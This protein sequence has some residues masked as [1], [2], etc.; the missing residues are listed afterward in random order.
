MRIPALF[1]FA[2]LALA[3]CGDGTGSGDLDRGEFQGDMRG[4]Y[5]ADLSGQ[6]VSGNRLLPDQ[7]QLLLTDPGED[8]VVFAYHQDDVFT[9]G[10]ETLAAVD[11]TFGIWAGVLVDDREFWADGGT[12]NIEAISDNG[13]RGSLRFTAVEIDRA[14][15]RILTDEVTVDVDFNTRYDSG[16]CGFNLIPNATR[17]RVSKTPR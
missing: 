15:E 11:E 5:R 2:G 8:V 12:M 14:S 7:D 6:A 3:A 1:A 13:I 9:R 17:I 10:R 4:E 16:C